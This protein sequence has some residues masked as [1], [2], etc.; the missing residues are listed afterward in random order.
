MAEVRKRRVFYL[1]GF[2][3]RGVAAYHRLFIEESKKQSAWS[4]I[5][6][7]VAERRRLNA[8]SSV[9]RAERPEAEGTTE[10]TFEFL[11]WDDIVREHWHTG[12]RR[13]YCIAL[14]VYWR[15]IFSTG[16]LGNV[17]RISKWPFVTGLAPGLVLFG[18]TMLA[19]LSG[20]SA[21]AAVEDY[22]P[23]IMWAPPLAA[24]AGFSILA[25]LGLWLD[26]MFALGWLLRTY[27]FVLNYG[28]GLIPAMDKR[29]DQFAQ[30]I[31]HYIE[32]SEDDEII[33]VGHSIGANVAVS[34]LARA[35][36]INPELWRR[37][38]PVG[39]LTLGGTIPMLGVM[40]TAKA[41]RKELGVLAASHEL[42][43]VDFSTSDDAASFP[44]VNPLVAAGVAGQEAASRLQ[45]L[46]GAFKEMLK[47]ETH[48][49]A[50]WN[51][52]RMHFQ[53]L[54]A[55]ERE[56]RH[57]YLSITTGR[58]LFRER[59]DGR[60]VMPAAFKSGKFPRAVH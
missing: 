59:F 51:L 3:P 47:P 13:L 49:R 18:I 30:R 5:T 43:W 16:V 35:V 26:R 23:H 57:D 32:T 1:S 2:D 60:T 38:S 52:F 29:M 8:L 27:D 53:Y 6:V 17:F 15:L 9:W 20:W 14:Q 44:L 10:T 21:Y 54:M 50:V 39:L 58:M 25:G 34:T 31:A 56:V 24:I 46:D 36:G 12:F 41:F 40:P 37:Y 55:S 28:L 11:H 42:H 33:V 45:V 48:R 19:F 4:G 22:F 7:Q